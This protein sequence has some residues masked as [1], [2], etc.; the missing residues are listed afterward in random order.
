M[1]DDRWKIAQQKFMEKRGRAK[2]RGVQEFG[3]RK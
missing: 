3:D 1:N 2:V